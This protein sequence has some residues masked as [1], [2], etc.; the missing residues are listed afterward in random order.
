[1]RA[2]PWL[3]CLLRLGACAAV[4]PVEPMRAANDRTLRTQGE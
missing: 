1:V 2:L 4:A 3:A